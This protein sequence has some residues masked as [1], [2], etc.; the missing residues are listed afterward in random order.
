MFAVLQSLIVVLDKGCS[1]HSRCA[2]QQR[3]WC[4]LLTMYRFSDKAATWSYHHCQQ[5]LTRSAD[6]NTNIIIT[7]LTFNQNVSILKP[8]CG[9]P[10]NRFLLFLWV[11]FMCVIPCICN[12]ASLDTH[13]EI[14]KNYLYACMSVCACACACLHWQGR[15]KGCHSMETCTLTGTVDVWLHM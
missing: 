14:N 8:S 12:W 4:S 13:R 3:R 11:F 1:V 9:N 6:D 15:T 7:R 2:L 5:S 10:D